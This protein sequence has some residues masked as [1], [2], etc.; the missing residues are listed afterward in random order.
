MA[1][2]RINRL[3]DTTEELLQSREP[4]RIALPKRTSVLD[5]DV[6]ADE[7]RQTKDN[8]LAEANKF[9]ALLEADPN[10]VPSRE[11]FAWLLAE[12][13][14]RA[15]LAVE[16]LELL[17]GMPAQSPV[18][19]AQW[20]TRIAHWQLRHLRDEQAGRKTL[21]RLI[22]DFPQTTEAFE[23]QCRLHL[24]DVET[25]LRRGRAAPNLGEPASC[26]QDAGAPSFSSRT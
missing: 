22:E 15:G 9:V 12:R 2:L 4:R 11:R 3:P 1:R 26:R 13:L 16:Q 6:T 8:A 7:S 18:K 19:Q 17:L 5:A 25:R 24:L 23:A 14:D 21:H 20:L 10:D